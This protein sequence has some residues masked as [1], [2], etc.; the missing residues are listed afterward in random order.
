MERPTSYSPPS[1]FFLFPFLLLLLF[2]FFPLLLS[3][4]LSA[5]FSLPLS[6]PLPFL[7][8]P[9]YHHGTDISPPPIRHTLL[10]LWLFY[11]FSTRA[12]T[13]FKYKRL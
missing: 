10:L 8:P 4:S 2:P 5:L 9:L 12:R 3:S 7:P 6:L 1:P 11:L 13:L